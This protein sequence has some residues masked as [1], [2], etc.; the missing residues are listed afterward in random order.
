MQRSDLQNLKIDGTN[1]FTDAK[2][3]KASSHSKNLLEKL[4]MSQ[5]QQKFGAT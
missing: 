5:T 2:S 1:Q 3:N 4:Q